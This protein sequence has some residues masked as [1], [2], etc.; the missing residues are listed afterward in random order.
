MSM[1]RLIGRLEE[2]KE[3]FRNTPNY[4]DAAKFDGD[5]T[6]T[7]G[8]VSGKDSK[9][10]GVNVANYLLSR[11]NDE[12]EVVGDKGAFFR[13]F[14]YHVA[15]MIDDNINDIVSKSVKSSNGGK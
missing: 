8:G 15:T 9:L 7:Q 11:L 14:A 6:I 12:S 2:A 10:L 13:E 3:A 5:I 1:N 4:R